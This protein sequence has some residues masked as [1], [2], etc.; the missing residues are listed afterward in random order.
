M[1][2]VV[3]VVVVVVVAIVEKV[4]FRSYGIEIRQRHSS[5]S[6]WAWRETGQRSRWKVVERSRAGDVLGPATG[7]W[8]TFTFLKCERTAQPNM[9]SICPL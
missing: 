4:R 2:V 6:S 9:H 8:A 3:V 7:S 1:C 5:G